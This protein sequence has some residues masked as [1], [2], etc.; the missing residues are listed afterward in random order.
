MVTSPP[1]ATQREYDPA[2]GFEPIPPEDYTGWFREVAAN[3]Q[4]ILAPDGSYLLNI[5]EHAVDGERHLYVKDLVIAHKRQWGWRF[6]DEFCWRKTDNGVPGGWGN[7]FKNAFEPVFHFC[8]QQ[9]I[10]FRPKA[11]GH[12]SED[13]FDYSPNNPRSMSGSGLLGTGARGSAA[14]PCKRSGITR[15]RHAID[16]DEGRYQ[17][18][19]RPSNVIEVKTESSQ[20]SHSAPFPRGLVEF[21]VKAFSDPGDLV[22]RSVSRKW[23]YNGRRPRAGPRGLRL[24][25]F[26]R[27]LRRDPAPD[28][29]SPPK[30]IRSLRRPASPF[31][32]VATGPRCRGAGIP[33]S[34]PARLKV[35]FDA[36]PTACLATEPKVSRKR[37]ST[38][39]KKEKTSMPEAATP[40]QGEREFE[41][42]TDES[43]KNANATGGEAHNENQ[44]SRTPT[45]SAP[46]TC[47]RIWTSRPRASR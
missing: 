45:S 13:C 42:G 39:T 47:T 19:A 40:N 18:I 28:R 37:S 7:R 6:V 16:D 14:D 21:F 35:P 41:T 34:A 11:V 32:V 38:Q 17:G 9:E 25:D 10:K 46:T 26:A 31:S 15:D 29:A 44:R 2:S 22:L 36:N 23:H 30:R 1:Y 4:A 5:K 20:G 12:V 33:R 43:F 27:V 3:I 8:R 24:R